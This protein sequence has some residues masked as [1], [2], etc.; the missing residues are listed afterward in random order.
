MCFKIRYLGEVESPFTYNK[1][2]HAKSEISKSLSFAFL[3][4]SFLSMIAHYCE[5]NFC[6]LDLSDYRHLAFHKR[7]S[8]GL[9]DIK[10]SETLTAF[11][12]FFENTGVMGGNLYSFPQSLTKTLSLTKLQSNSSEPSF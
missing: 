6:F 11:I 7:H 5:L 4:N 3:I 10:N 12:L 9:L 1:R 8:S 2:C